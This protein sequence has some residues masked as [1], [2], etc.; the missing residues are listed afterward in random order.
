MP[1]NELDHP[2]TGARL[3]VETPN[4]RRI[5]NFIDYFEGLG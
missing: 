4:P 5:Q 1:E 2:I 3:R